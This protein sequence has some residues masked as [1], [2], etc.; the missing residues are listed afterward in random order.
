[1]AISTAGTRLDRFLL[2][3]VPPWSSRPVRRVVRAAVGTS[4]GRP[5]GVQGRRPSPMSKGSGHPCSGSGLEGVSDDG[6]YDPT[7]R[8]ALVPSTEL[9]DRGPTV[10]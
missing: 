2:A 5:V 6:A 3:V 1:M 7:G 10:D 9:R 4:H 8:R